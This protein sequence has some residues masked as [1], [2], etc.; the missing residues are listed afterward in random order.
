MG[1]DADKMVELEKT[2]K[3][4]LMSA[5]LALVMAVTPAVSSL[6]EG[7]D[8]PTQT[9]GTVSQKEVTEETMIENVDMFSYVTCR[10]K[11]ND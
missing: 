11:S 7:S 4:K 2:A 10:Y 9:F 8:Q 6:A 1:G 5:A 3:T